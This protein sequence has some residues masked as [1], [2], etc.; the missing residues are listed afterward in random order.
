MHHGGAGV[1]G[2][3]A[4]GS[5]ETDRTTASIQITHQ[6][7]RFA[8]A[9]AAG[10]SHEDHG[11]LRHGVA[12]TD[13]Q[14]LDDALQRRGHVHRRLVGLQRDERVLRRDGVAGR[15]V[16][17]D[18]GN[19]VEDL[20]D[21]LELGQVEPAVQ[22][23]EIGHAR[24]THDRE[25]EIVDMEVDDVEL[26]GAA[27]QLLE[28]ADVRCQIV[29]NRRVE[30]QR[31]GPARLEL[32]GRLAVGAGEQGDVMPEL[33]QLVAEISDDP[34]GAAIEQRRHRLAERRDLGDPHGL[35]IADMRGGAQHG[36][37]RRE[38]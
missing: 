21:R 2:T 8:H 38:G 36:R 3:R 11:A 19:V 15:D 4:Y 17:L 10:G 28:H 18:D 16:H 20:V 23:G 29:A 27:G 35:A 26:V 6:S 33:D 25:S 34:L 24:A 30:A 1:I 22:R 12:D 37:F 14:L 13:L 9:C 31:V 7:H 5:D 32:R